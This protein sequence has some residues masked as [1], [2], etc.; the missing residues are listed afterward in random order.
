MDPAG[1]SK[2]ISTPSSPFPLSS[3]FHHCEMPVKWVAVITLNEIFENS[4]NH[5]TGRQYN[6]Q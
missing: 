3:S 2:E 5:I 6:K 1:K 4:T